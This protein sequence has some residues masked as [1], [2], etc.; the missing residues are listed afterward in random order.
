ML[1]FR[2]DDWLEGLLRPL[3]LADPNGYVHVEIQA[4]DLRFAAL[5]ALTLLLLGARRL[6]GADSRPLV[7]SLVGLWLIFYV[8]VFAVGNGRYFIVG[9]LLAGPLIV[10]AVARTPFTRSMRLTVL[11]GVLGLQAVVVHQHFHHG[12]WALAYWTGSGPGL[13]LTDTPLRREPAVFLTTT[14]IS[15][16]ILVP[17]FNAQSRW[18]NVAG[19]VNITPDK[20][21]WSALRHLLA[22]R[23]PKYVVLPILAGAAGAQGQPRDEVSRMLRAILG[24]HGLQRNDRPCEVLPSRL[25]IPDRSKGEG[26]TRPLAYWFCPLED[27]P[28]QLPAAAPDDGAP[29]VEAFNAVE[30]ACPRFFPPGGGKLVV[31]GAGTALQHYAESD[32]RLYVDEHGNVMYRYLRAMNPTRIGSVEDVQ[33]GH[34]TLE[35]EKLPGRYRYPWQH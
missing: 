2:P 29:W 18:A 33:R 8:W 9:M 28:M 20:P 27:A 1:R 6:S 35:C 5:G 31:T 14:S 16:S 21:E 23:L 30:Q 7:R 17:Q 4:P 10:A 24:Q 34:F 15:Q 25:Q 3:I 11:A 13:P 12:T 32:T 26:A 22:T 19:Q